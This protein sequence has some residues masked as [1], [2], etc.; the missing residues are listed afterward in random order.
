MLDVNLLTDKEFCVELDKAIDNQINTNNR[1]DRED[2][3]AE[4]IALI[5]LRANGDKKTY[6]KWMIHYDG[7]VAEAYA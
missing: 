2:A 3:R 1:Y 4:A 7:R 5:N 6:R